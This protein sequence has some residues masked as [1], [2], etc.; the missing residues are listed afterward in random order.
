MS[1]LISDFISL[2]YPKT[3]I[4][5]DAYISNYQ[6]FLCIDCLHDLPKSYSY[7]DEI[8]NITEKLYS[9]FPFVKAKSFLLF[10]EG[11]KT[12]KLLHE[13][14]YHQQPLLSKHLGIIFG[15]NLLQEDFFETIDIIT[16]VPLHIKKE[17]NR[18]YNQ[19]YYFAEGLSEVSKIPLNK[20]LLKR[21]INT[22][23]QTQKNRA[24]RIENV[25]NAF[26]PVETKKILGKH[27]LLVDDIVT[28]G[29]TLEA[30]ATTL[31]T[32]KTKNISIATIAIAE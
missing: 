17:K 21:I 31:L 20:N 16:A 24:E 5:C 18:G 2:F 11:N 27:I 7:G 32:A 4:C 9:K 13:L 3:C 23:T 29:A 10:K 14:K 25:Q 28:T 1:L 19:S 8:N 22:K 12:Q 30:C 6:E 15:K 26:E